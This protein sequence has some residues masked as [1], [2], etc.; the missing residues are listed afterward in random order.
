VSP[1]VVVA[2]RAVP[3]TSGSAGY[4]AFRGIYPVNARRR[5]VGE[6]AR[7]GGNYRITKYSSADGLTDH[8]AAR[9]ALA[10]G[11]SSAVTP[12]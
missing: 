8:A 12:L 2:G 3:I 1:Q 11:R 9:N 4:A 5:E 10:D 6:T 7:Y